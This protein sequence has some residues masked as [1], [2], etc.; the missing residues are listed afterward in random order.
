MDY[1]Q[2]IKK[3]VIYYID[4]DT[5]EVNFFKADTNIFADALTDLL[6]SREDLHE[7]RI[8]AVEMIS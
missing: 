1:L 2:D 7:F 6:I 4:K 8:I 3:T 5:N